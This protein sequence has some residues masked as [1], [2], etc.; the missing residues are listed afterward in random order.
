M[1]DFAIGIELAHGVA[2]DCPQSGD[3][4]ELDRAATFGRARYQLR[5]CEDDRP[6]AFGSR[7]LRK[8]AGFLWP[9][10]APGR[11]TLKNRRA[12]V[13]VSSRRL[14]GERCVL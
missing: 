9:L 5:C 11:G 10:G 1:G 7:A 8:L 13:V 14:K 3:A 6:A 2:V 12:G 4:R